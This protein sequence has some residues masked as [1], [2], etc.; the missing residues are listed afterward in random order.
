MS[1]A[2]PEQ[3]HRFSKL[4]LTAL[5]IDQKLE[6]PA[7]VMMY[8][9]TKASASVQAFVAKSQRRLQEFVEDAHAWASA[10]EAAEQE[11]LSDWDLI[12]KLASKA[13]S[14][15][16]GAC[17][18]WHAADSFFTR[19]AGTIDRGF[20]ASSLAMVICRGPSKTSRVP[21]VLGPT[22]A[23]KSTVLDPLV[24]VFGFQN[25]LHRPG[26]KATM[27]LANCAKKGKRFI[28]WDEYRPVEFAAR[29]T[30]PVGTFLS[31]FGGG[32]LEIQVSQS[33]QNGN[34]ELQWKRGAAMT[35]KDE[36]S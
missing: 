2:V 34:A 21:L 27:A 31:L 17:Q 12:S 3:V 13:C 4:D 33:F 23:A 1:S 6:S 15:G 29:G 7:Q 20:F 30:V 32:S 16:D 36:G 10:K 35:A 19:N 8:A 14:C 11:K 22:C 24:E 26:E 9:Q 25:V 18:W 28:Y 5:I